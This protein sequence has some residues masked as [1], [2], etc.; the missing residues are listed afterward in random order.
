VKTVIL[1]HQFF[2]NLEKLVQ[3]LEFDVF[4]FSF[5]SEPIKIV[6]IILITGKGQAYCLIAQD[7]SVVNCCLVDGCLVDKVVELK[8]CC[9][10]VVKI[11]CLLSLR[12]STWLGMCLLIQSRYGCQSRNRCN[13][14]KI[15]CFFLSP[16]GGLVCFSPLFERRKF[17]TII[18]YLAESN[19]SFEFLRYE[20]CGLSQPE[21]TLY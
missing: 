3:L 13:R 4:F 8:G 17:R 10:C 15:W 20:M 16:G 1:N 21:F 18:V 9:R 6:S 12:L 11:A 5:H 14:S 7:S 2:L 19:E